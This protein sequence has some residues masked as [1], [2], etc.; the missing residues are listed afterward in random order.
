MNIPLAKG[1]APPARLA[2]ALGLVLMLVLTAVPPASADDEPPAPLKNPQQRLLGK[3]AID[4]NLNQ[5]LPL[6]LQFRDEEGDAVRL[7][8]YF[9]ERPVVLALVYYQ[10]PKLCNQVL[11]GMT[12]ALKSVDFT[13]GE[14]Y[15]VVVVSFDPREG[16]EL[17]KSKKAAYM[18][19]FNREGAERSWHFLTG[20][21]PE[22]EALAEAVGFHYEFDEKSQQFAH[23]SA[24]YL[25]TPDGRLSRYFYGIDYKP[26][27]LRLGLIESSAG[28]IG[29]PVDAVLLYCFHYDPLTGRYGLVIHRVL[30]LAGGAT[31]LG[32]GA[33][34]A[35]MLVWEKKGRF[36]AAE[37]NPPAE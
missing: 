17:A 29:S 15:E 7:G 10:C 1:L 18:Y 3:V 14:D 35:V 30:Q 5:Q 8:Q 4:Q 22:I 11:N 28:K 24:I 12:T 34:I 23:A 9:G 32:L 33:F 2:R 21:S 20:E 13:S 31:A 26:R 16:P 19:K 6:D 25:A 37:E 36:A 27:D